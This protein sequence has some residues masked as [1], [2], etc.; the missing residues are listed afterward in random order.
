MCANVFRSVLSYVGSSKLFGRK[1]FKENTDQTTN[2]LIMTRNKQKLLQMK[3]LFFSMDSENRADRLPKDCKNVIK[4][5]NF[6][7][8]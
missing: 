8:K 3:N 1:K 4:C 7:D 5:D 2:D 6:I